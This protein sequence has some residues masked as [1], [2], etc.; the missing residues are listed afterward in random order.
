[1]TVEFV[2]KD[3]KVM[4]SNAVVGYHHDTWNNGPIQ[5]SPQVRPKDPPTETYE[6]SLGFLT[7]VR[8]LLRNVVVCTKGW[9]Q[10]NSRTGHV[11]HLMH[12]VLM[13]TPLT[14]QRLAFTRKLWLFCS[15]SRLLDSQTQNDG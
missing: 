4:V 15:Y 11:S 3:I 1:V 13:E 5:K 6:D 12:R 8:K 9:N 2:S 7:C 10:C 14:R